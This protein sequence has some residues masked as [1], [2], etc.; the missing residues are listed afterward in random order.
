M[1]EPKVRYVNGVSARSIHVELLRALADASF[2]PVATPAL[3]KSLGTSSQ[4]VVA[5]LRP[6]LSAGLVTKHTTRRGRTY[7]L[8]EEGRRYLLRNG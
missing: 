4:A 3:A 7:E 1:R 2:E 6:L 8:S 5:K